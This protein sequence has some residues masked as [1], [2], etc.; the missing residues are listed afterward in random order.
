MWGTTWHCLGGL[1]ETMTNPIRG[2]HFYWLA[3]QLDKTQ[4]KAICVTIRASL[5]GVTMLTEL[6][7]RIMSV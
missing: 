2:S 4:I 1:M 3:F 7:K 5:L 6:F